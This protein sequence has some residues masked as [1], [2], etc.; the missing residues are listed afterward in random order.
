MRKWL[1]MSLAV[2]TM[3]AGLSA[4]IPATPASAHQVKCINYP[5]DPPFISDSDGHLHGIGEFWCNF[6][7]DVLV[8]TAT[9]ERWN[10][11]LGRWVPMAQDASSRPHSGYAILMPEKACATNSPWHSWRLTTTQEGFHHVWGNKTVK[12]SGTFRVRCA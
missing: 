4:A 10:G 8:E 6:A 7:P 12:H 5:P 9:L 1:L 11:T 3:A 2:L